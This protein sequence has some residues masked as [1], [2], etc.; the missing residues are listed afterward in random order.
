MIGG[1][2]CVRS[3]LDNLG[4]VYES[5]EG[6]RIGLLTGPAA[7][8]RNLR[9]SADILHSQF[10]LTCLF[11]PEH[12]IRGDLQAGDAVAATVDLRTGLP[13]HSLYG[14]HQAPSEAELSDVDVLVVDLQD[15]GA[16]FYTYIY[17]LAYTMESCAKAG[18]PVVVL[19]RPN[20]LGGKHVEGCLLKSPFRSFVGRFAL[21]A[22]YG[23]TIGEFA[24]WLNQAEHLD[25]RLIVSHLSG[26]RRPMYF[27]E[28][29]LPW[30]SPSPNIPTVDSA[31]AYVGTCLFE[32]TNLSEGRGTTRPFEQ[33]GAPWLDQA[34][35]MRQIDPIAIQGAGLRPC[36]FRPTFSKH[37]GMSCAGI[38]LHVFDRELFR[39]YAAGIALLD[40]IRATHPEFAFLPPSTDGRPIIDLLAG[41]DELRL[42]W[43]DRDDF[44]NRAVQ[45]AADFAGTSKG[46]YLYPD[47]D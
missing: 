14:D 33:I 5:L 19:D 34:R 45:E 9:H 17:T 7:I 42:T 38:Q 29:G 46:Y 36:W 35:V 6:Q 37:A 4:T 27:D 41:T 12:G 24:I 28:T 26:W 23:L 20:P 39:P 3:G 25:C 43:L 16:R 22:R 1:T 32:G 21:P 11:A 10:H 8:D 44:M 13:V 30:V 2:R 40:T 31:L 15:V 47:E 18:I